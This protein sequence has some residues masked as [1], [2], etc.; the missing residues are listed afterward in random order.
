[1]SL[2]NI[3]DGTEDRMLDVA[4]EVETAS[5]FNPDAIDEPPDGAQGATNLSEETENALKRF[6]YEFERLPQSAVLILHGLLNRRT[7]L[8]MARER[9]VSKQCVHQILKNALKNSPWLDAVRWQKRPNRKHG[10]KRTR[11]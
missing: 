7:L 3:A 6:L 10:K 11:P 1:M 8:D 9:G 2:D 5:T 4:P